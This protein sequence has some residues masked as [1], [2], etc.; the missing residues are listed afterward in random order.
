MKTNENEK[1]CPVLSI[2]CEIHCAKERC[3]WFMDGAC[4]VVY[5]GR[6]AKMDFELNEQTAAN[7]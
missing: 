2:G 7:F 5:L 3:A 1:T 4:A 6:Q